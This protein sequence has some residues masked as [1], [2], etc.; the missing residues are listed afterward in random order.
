M[1]SGIFNRL[2]R[3]SLW[4][5]HL[6]SP[7]GAAKSLRYVHFPLIYSTPVYA[8]LEAYA[9]SLVQFAEWSGL[10]AGVRLIDDCVVEFDGAAFDRQVPLL[11]NKTISDTELGKKLAEKSSRLMEGLPN[12]CV[13]LEQ[14]LD[15]IDSHYR[16]RLR[17]AYES[18]VD[19]IAVNQFNICY[20]T[21]YLFLKEK[22]GQ[23]DVFKNLVAQCLYGQ[24]FSYMEW[25]KSQTGILAAMSVQERETGRMMIDYYWNTSFLQDQHPQTNGLAEALFIADRFG[26]NRG[27][28][29][30]LSPENLPAAPPGIIYDYSAKRTIH[31]STNTIQHILM[32]LQI[33]GVNEEF[34]HYWQARFFRLMRL[35]SPVEGSVETDS[36]KTILTRIGHDLH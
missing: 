25:F 13:W 5:F 23:D 22:F 16:H 11:L 9:R 7:E 35:L 21:A 12:D 6:S 30:Y 33:L 29:F 15:R 31:H 19:L 34:R 4:A 10:D 8:E 20:E 14:N 2:G 32:T 17:A 27:L 24:R 1:L 26:F 36:L 18:V 28:Q 3:R